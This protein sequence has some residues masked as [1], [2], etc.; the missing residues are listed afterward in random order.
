MITLISAIRMF[1]LFVNSCLFDASFNRTGLWSIACLSFHTCAATSDV[2]ISPFCYISKVF[3]NPSFQICFC[4]SY[5]YLLTVLAIDLISFLAECY[6]SIW[7]SKDFWWRICSAVWVLCCGVW[8]FC[9]IYDGFFN[10]INLVY[11]WILLLS[12]LVTTLKV[13]L[14]LLLQLFSSSEHWSWFK[15]L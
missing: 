6:L 8:R 1:S 2:S 9:W 3:F 12:L 7:N 13:T 4:L 14:L 15:I 10:L 5:I 11:I